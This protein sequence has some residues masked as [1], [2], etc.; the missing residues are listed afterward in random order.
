[1][2][3]A[4]IDANINRVSE[5]LRVIEDYLRFV[6][7]NEPLTLKLAAF[8]HTLNKT[9]TNFT[10]HLLIRD[11]DKDQRANMTPPKRPN[12]EDL[13]KANFKRVQEGLRVLEEY[14]G[15]AT[16]STLRYDAYM[17]EK[18]V[19]LNAI[20]PKISKGFYLISDDVDILL[21]GLEWGVSFVQLRD[22]HASKDVIYQKAVDFQARKPKTDI[23]FI[24]NDFLDIAKAVEADGLHT[25]QDDLPVDVLRN[26]W[27]DHKLFG[28]TTHD[29]S[30]GQLAVEQ[31][32]DYVSVGPI[33]ETPSKPNREGI[34]FDYLQKADTLGVPFVAIGGIN[35]DLIEDVM[36]FKP[37]LVGVIRDYASIP[38]LT[39]RYFS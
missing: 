11:T 17:L 39:A 18:E 5:G 12:I 8:R 24:I 26:I 15:N 14:T 20:K 33:W 28:R 31:G 36:A 19:F 2:T 13:L 27:G 38:E 4:I 22:K 25:G 30:Q 37:P 10:D 16:Y 35:S 34:G 7:Q 23:P 6:V 21:K 32:A 9:E 3:H 1:M 29:F